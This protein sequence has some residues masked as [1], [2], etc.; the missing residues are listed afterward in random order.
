M[1]VSSTDNNLYRIIADGIST[2]GRYTPFVQNYR[3]QLFLRTADVTVGLTW[4]EDTADAD[5]KM[6]RPQCATTLSSL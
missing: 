2:G 5:E 1:K 6:V 4:P 3:P